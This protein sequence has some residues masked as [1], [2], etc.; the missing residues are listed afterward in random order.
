MTAFDSAF[1]YVDGGGLERLSRGVRGR[2]SYV[3][4]QGLWNGDDP[5]F[6]QAAAAARGWSYQEV[7]SPSGLCF[8][9]GFP[10][11][12]F[13][14]R[15]GL[16]SFQV[17][18][19]DCRATSPS[20]MA[21]ICSYRVT[22]FVPDRARKH[23]G[24]CRLPSRKIESAPSLSLAEPL[25]PLGPSR[26][27]IKE[28]GLLDFDLDAQAQGYVREALQILRVHYGGWPALAEAIGYHSKAV[29]NVASGHKKATPEMAQRV[30]L[31]GEVNL[32]ELLS[33]RFPNLPRH[34]N[35]A[36]RP[37]SPESRIPSRPPW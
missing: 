3:A 7:V 4:L 28:P 15:P 20:S 33:G 27:R 26:G 25:S 22:V 14:S 30:A 5:G 10:D 17:D 35:L 18:D 19:R 8:D 6:W 32:C 31:L 37:I 21:R 24:R 11:G 34:K 29:A 2:M 13:L 36:I 23:G 12:T 1:T 16:T 9:V